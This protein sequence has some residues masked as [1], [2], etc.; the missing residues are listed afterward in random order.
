MRIGLIIAFLLGICCCVFAQQPSSRIIGEDF[1]DD[2]DIYTIV[3]DLEHN[4]WIGTDEGLV[5]Y[6]GNEFI[7]YTNNELKSNAIF[8]LAL[9]NYGTVFCYNLSGQILTMKDDS[10][11]LYYQIPDSLNVGISIINFDNQD[12]LII[13]TGLIFF[14]VDQR[15]E[16]TIIYKPK[17]GKGYPYIIANDMPRLLD[18]TL[19]FLLPQM[20]RVGEW[21]NGKLTIKECVYKD[22]T[23]TALHEE[24]ILILAKENF[25][26]F[27]Y[28]RLKNNTW[29]YS[30]PVVN[31]CTDWMYHAT[32]DHLNF[33]FSCREG[34]VYSYDKN[35]NK[36]HKSKFYAKKSISTIK[37]DKEGNLWLGTFGEGLIFIPNLAVIDFTS[38]AILKEEKV[39]AIVSGNNGALYVASR[40]GTFY[41]ID[42]NLNVK[43]IF[44]KKQ[45]VINN[46]L[47]SPSKQQLYFGAGMVDVRTRKYEDKRYTISKEMQ[48]VNEDIY[49]VTSRRG[50]HYYNMGSKDKQNLRDRFFSNPELACDKNNYSVTKDLTYGSICLGRSD[51]FYYDTIS[52]ALWV[53]KATD[54]LYGKALPLKVIKYNGNSIITPSICQYNKETYIAT[55]KGILVFEDTVFK[56]NILMTNGLLSNNIKKIILEG[57]LLYVVSDKGVQYL[58]LKTK[59]T[60]TFVGAD[61][62][63]SNRIEHIAIDERYIWLATGK[64][65]QRINKTVLDQKSR[66]PRVKFISILVNGEPIDGLEKQKFAFNENKIIFQF[67]GSSYRSQGGL[68]YEYRLKGTNDDWTTNDQNVVRYNALGAGDYVFEVRA[69]DQKGNTSLTIS[70][71]FCI[72]IPYWQEWWFVILCTFGV[73]VVVA[74]FFLIRIQ[75][76]K[77]QNRL[78]LEKKA[79]ESELIESRQTALRS[80]MNPHFMFNALN[81]IQELIMINEKQMAGHYLGKFAD[82]MRIYLNHSQ[83]TVVTLSEELEALRLYLDLE[84]VRFEDT[85]TIHL[86]VSDKIEKDFITLPPMLLQPYIENA[87][88]HGLLHKEQ[89]R[90]LWIKFDYKKEEAVICCTIKDN[91]VGRERSAEINKFRSKHHKSFSVSATQKRLDL[92]NY[93]RESLI[94]VATED[95]K[96]KKQQPMGTKV[97][98]EIPLDWNGLS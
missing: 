75:L 28:H 4:I 52:K 98:L 1:F 23:T 9:D 32:T 58:N 7:T 76:L 62:L 56:Q 31:D 69:I 93:N 45:R 87:F 10:L 3:D 53:G 60:H 22:T 83:K 44:Q 80:Q 63:L 43:P 12:N 61:G 51:G 81:S 47:W 2:K 13:S 18:G 96:N 46:L 24:A 29:S 40:S 91:G 39:T 14:R 19:V 72:A 42:S 6:D 27:L 11:Q 67:I 88:K 55:G 35:E 50:I 73:A 48:W 59:V 15:K 54:L 16:I 82:L 65:I 41:K 74:L 97:T 37:K 25:N 94:V 92:L 49:I 17:D 8:G 68:M 89:D 57:D 70:Y 38:N 66:I 33:W 78:L 5:R 95:L 20:H 79:I 26:F 86:E 36:L 34:G 85:L 30:G 71:E 64:G 77:D 21:L 84:K 90:I